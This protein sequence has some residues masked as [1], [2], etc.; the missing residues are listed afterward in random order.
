[1][2]II[3]GKNNLQETMYNKINR[4]FLMNYHNYHYTKLTCIDG[5]Q[6]LLLD[7]SFDCVCICEGSDILGFAGFYEETEDSSCI[8]VFKLAHLLVDANSRG[9]GLGTL[10]EDNRFLMVK[11]MKGEKIIYA[12][13]VENPRNS[14]YMKLNRGFSICGFKYHYRSSDV[15]RGNSLMLVNSEGVNNKEVSISMTIPIS[16]MTQKVIAKGN[17]NM[18]FINSDSCG[19]QLSKNEYRT[20]CEITGSARVQYK[21][22]ITN[23]K[24]LGRYISRIKAVS[25]LDKEIA[26]QEETFGIQSDDVRDGYASVVVNPGIEGFSMLDNCLIQNRFY[27]VTYIPYINDYYGEVE[28]QYLPGGIKTILDDEEVSEEG[29]QFLREIMQDIG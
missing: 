19:N 14:I 25:I 13:C 4:L 10:L 28:Y 21:A 15:K 6:S 29:K 2:E 9:R 20:V 7:P 1:M 12:S 23:D 8:R 18:A 27:P 17:H 11:K 5:I 3:Y 22:Q 24:S 16:R 26:Q